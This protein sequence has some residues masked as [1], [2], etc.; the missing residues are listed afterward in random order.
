M[1]NFRI[2][3]NGID[4]PY[5]CNITFIYFFPKDNGWINELDIDTKYLLNNL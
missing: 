2:K 4:V 3:K 5:E 1:Y